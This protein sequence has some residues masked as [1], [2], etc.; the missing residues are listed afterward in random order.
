MAFITRSALKALWIAAFQPAEANYDDVWDSFE[1]A[2]QTVTITAGA[3]TSMEVRYTGDVAPTLTKEAAGEYRIDLGLLTG[4]VSFTWRESSGTLTGANSIK[5]KVRDGDGAYRHI[6]P[7]VFSSTTGDEYTPQQGVTRKFT[8][9]IAGD[10]VLELANISGVP[11]DWRVI[12]TI[13]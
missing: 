13:L 1:K 11:G 12:G 8:E 5:L 3:E 6:L 2:T 9:P 10:T 7:A 4:R